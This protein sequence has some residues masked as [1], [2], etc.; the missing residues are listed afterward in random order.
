MTSHLI[1]DRAP[2]EDQFIR[3][4]M[5]L[6][7]SIAASVWRKTSRRYELEDLRAYGVIGALKAYR[8]WSPTGG[9]CFGAFVAVGVRHEIYNGIRDHMALMSRRTMQRAIRDGLSLGTYAAD[10]LQA[11]EP[12]CP[13]RAAIEAIDASKVREAVRKLPRRQRDAVSGMLIGGTWEDVALTLGLHRGSVLRDHR[14]G[15]ETLRRRLRV[16]A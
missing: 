15:V 7:G 12:V 8:K 2:T 5:A 1:V 10:A 13:E 9:G 3:D 16:S 4:A 14:M 6:I 11:A